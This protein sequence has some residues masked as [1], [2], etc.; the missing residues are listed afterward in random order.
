M[1]LSRSITM[2]ATRLLENLLIMDCRALVPV[3]SVLRRENKQPTTIHTCCL[4]VLVHKSHDLTKLVNVD[5]CPLVAARRSKPTCTFNYRGHRAILLGELWLMDIC[6]F[7]MV[8]RDQ[9]RI[10]IVHKLCLSRPN[11]GQ[12]EAMVILVTNLEL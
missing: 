4:L 8:H 12:N 6:R 5:S 2:L 11:Q 10:L 1:C 3:A 7:E 9:E